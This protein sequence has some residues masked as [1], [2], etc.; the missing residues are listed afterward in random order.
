MTDFFERLQQDKPVIIDGGTGTEMEKKGAKMEEKG[1][2]VAYRGALGIGMGCIH[3]LQPAHRFAILLQHPRDPGGRE[4]ITRWS[5]FSRHSSR[6]TRCPGNSYVQHT[7]KVAGLPCC[8]IW[9]GDGNP[10][11]TTRSARTGT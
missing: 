1:W 6:Y 9:H 10:T 7:L 5:D 8:E 2:S 3:G 4:L 11:T